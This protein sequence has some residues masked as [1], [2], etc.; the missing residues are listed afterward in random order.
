MSQ[1]EGLAAQLQPLQDLEDR[2][3]DGAQPHFVRRSAHFGRALRRRG[4]GRLLHRHVGGA[5]FAFQNQY[6]TNQRGMVE[7]A[8]RRA[9]LKTISEQILEL[10]GAG[11]RFEAQRCRRAARS[12]LVRA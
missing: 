12:G 6:H 11:R 2:L 4:P 8:S 3:D 10:L 5:P 9:W 1:V 7:G